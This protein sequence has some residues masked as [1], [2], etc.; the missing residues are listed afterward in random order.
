MVFAAEWL[1]FITA[2]PSAHHIL[3]ASSPLK[4]MLGKIKMYILVWHKCIFKNIH[5]KKKLELSSAFNVVSLWLQIII[6]FFPVYFFNQPEAQWEV[7][8]QLSNKK[9]A[10][11]KRG[12]C[13][14]SHSRSRGNL[15]LGFW[16][17]RVFE[18]FWILLT[19]WS[20]LIAASPL[21]CRHTALQGTYLLH[22][23]E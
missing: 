8:I 17:W 2:N 5:I 9:G 16:Y 19:R 6:S 4:K 1:Y 13:L 11:I 20:W 14:Q 7:F 23:L 10:R 18:V 12:V 22:F 21:S 15:L 3:S